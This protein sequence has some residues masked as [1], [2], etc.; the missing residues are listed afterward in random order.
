M[1]S[2]IFCIN[3]GNQSHCNWILQHHRDTQLAIP[4]NR[5]LSMQNKEKQP[6]VKRLFSL[7]PHAGLCQSILSQG[8][9]L[10]EANVK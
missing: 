7:D 5:E 9:Q 4:S 10:R 8:I 2:K 3:T 6:A 1:D